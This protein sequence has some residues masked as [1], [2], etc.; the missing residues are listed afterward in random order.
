MCVTKNVCV[1]VCTCVCVYMYA[2]VRV[3]VYM[4]ACVRVCVWERGTEKRY[5]EYRDTEREEELE[6][7]VHVYCICWY[8]SWKT[9]R[10]KEM[11]SFFLIDVPLYVLHQLYVKIRELQEL[12]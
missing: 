3:C 12:R 11:L 5:T 1:Y 8:S 10:G 6:N 4:Y 9:E 7:D 2:C